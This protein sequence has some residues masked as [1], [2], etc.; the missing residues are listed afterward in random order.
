MF[1]C[2]DTLLGFT[3]RYGWP[4]G[5]VRCISEGAIVVRDSRLQLFIF[6]YSKDL[7]I[8]LDCGLLEFTYSVDLYRVLFGSTFTDVL[9]AV[10]FSVTRAD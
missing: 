6:E 1:T 2:I 4:V 3:L 7:F 10:L 8:K 5:I 9:L